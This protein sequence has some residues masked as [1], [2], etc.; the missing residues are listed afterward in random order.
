MIGRASSV[1]ARFVAK[2]DLGNSPMVG[3]MSPEGYKQLPELRAD[4]Q[5]VHAAERSSFVV[6]DPVL[7]PYFRIDDV[8][9][10]LLRRWSRCRTPCDSV[11]ANDR[12]D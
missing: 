6:F 12:V 10:M 5:V 2:D 9:A 11:A 7:Q 8:T 3:I 4:L 1:S